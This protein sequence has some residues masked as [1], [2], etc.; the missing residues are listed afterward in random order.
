MAAAH[1]A[2]LIMGLAIRVPRQRGHGQP[3]LACSDVYPGTGRGMQ[4]CRHIN[5]WLC[6]GTHANMCGWEM[7][8]TSS[9]ERPRSVD[10]VANINQQGRDQGPRAT[11][12][13]TD[14]HAVDTQ[15]SNSRS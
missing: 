2:S 15:Y 6:L 3:Y 14:R 8:V 5:A 4:G 10:V 7:L 12:P 9:I 1:N 11:G 13:P